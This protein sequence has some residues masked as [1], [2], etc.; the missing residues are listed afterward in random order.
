MERRLVITVD[1]PAGSGKSTVS[2]ILAKRVSYM[3]LD[4][5]LLYRAV[6][7]RAMQRGVFIV[8]DEALGRLCDGITIP[9]E[10][11]GEMRVLIEGE[12]ISED[13]RTEEIGMLA[14]SV[15]AVPAVREG[16][17][18]LQ[19]SAGRQGGIV[20]EGRDMGTVVF[21]DA[22]VKFFLDADVD[23][24]ARRRYLQL[25][26]NG[27]NADRSEVKRGLKV[28]DHQDMTREIAPLKPADDSVI[29]D[30]TG[31]DIG[32]VVEKME[33]IVEERAQGGGGPVR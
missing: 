10:T 32:G 11:E 3:Y 14:S 9:L 28:R 25:I 6:A 30:T 13:L 1:G 23:E 27:K 7:W 20:A 18:P 5:G 29:I 15:S 2:R 12:D 26:E 33:M 19:K 8:D 21:P 16:L 24:R 17:L 4:T 31:I 22:D